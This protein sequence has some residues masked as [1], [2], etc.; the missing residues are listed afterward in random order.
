[1]SIARAQGARHLLFFVS[2]LVL[3]GFVVKQKKGLSEE[4]LRY[5]GKAEPSGKFVVGLCYFPGGLNS[6]FG[7]GKDFM[8]I[9]IF[10]V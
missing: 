5:L 4:E 9:G 10:I 8:H 6:L 7:G 3:R 2:L 1:M